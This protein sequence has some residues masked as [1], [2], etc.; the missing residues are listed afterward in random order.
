MKKYIVATLILSACLFTGCATDKGRFSLIDLDLRTPEQIVASEKENNVIYQGT[1]QVPVEA[2][3]KAF[4]VEYLFKFL[5]VVKGRL[6]ILSLEW[7]SK[8]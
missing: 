8:E 1:N 5:E 2:E 6:R 3:A 4:P 7:K